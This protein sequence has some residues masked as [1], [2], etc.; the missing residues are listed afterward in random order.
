MGDEPK[1][2]IRVARSFERCLDDLREFSAGEGRPHDLDRF[3]GELL[4]KLV[5]MLEPYP[6]IGRDLLAS[7]PGSSEARLLRDRLLGRLTEG[8]TVRKLVVRE[9]VVLCVERHGEVV[10]IAIRHHRQLS[11]DF[12]AFGAP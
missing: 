6:Q 10:L 8:A 1:A 5:T 2:R 4:E 12:E 3:E 11:F 9:H 7:L